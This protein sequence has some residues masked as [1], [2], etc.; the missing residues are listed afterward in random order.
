MSTAPQ[1]APKTA[2]KTAMI[3][4]AGRGER[5]QP[6]TAL[7]PKPLIEVMGR[8]MIERSLDR[9]AL[10]GVE[11]AAVNTHYLADKLHARLEKRTVPEIVTVH[12]AETLLD[13][14]GG[15]ANALEHLGDA[16]FYVL[17][18]DVFWLDGYTPALSRLAAA[19]D[20]TRMDALLL[21]APTAWAIGYEGRGDFVLDI[22]GRA[23]RRPECEVAPHAFTGLQI[24]HPRLFKD[25][26]DGPFSLNL[27]YDRA[28]AAER[29][30]GL[31]HD[32]LWFHIGTPDDLTLAEDELDEM[33][34]RHE[35][36]GDGLTPA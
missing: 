32:G 21:M 8:P 13:T 23:Q 30:Y 36:L 33:G 24:L 26:P 6:L 7:K 35:D 14:G 17:N 31:P 15:V 12:E 18:G 2:P 10:A 4:A 3:L 5:M 29:L 22:A 25:V 16:P 34:F 19:W 20:D 9:L 11:R 1:A 28:I 27:L